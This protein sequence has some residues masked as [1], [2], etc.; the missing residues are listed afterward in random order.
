MA[1]RTL[2]ILIAMVSLL[3]VLP[4][5]H[6]GGEV[7]VYSYRQPFL[8]KP[9]LD[10]FSENTGIK[11]N[12]L[13]APKGLIERVKTE[14]KNSPADVVLTVD[15]GRL[16]KAVT[17]GVSQPVKSAAIEANVP[18]AY[19][20]NDGSWFGRGLWRPWGR[21]S[22]GGAYRAA[23]AHPRVMARSQSAWRFGRPTT[24]RRGRKPSNAST[25]LIPTSGWSWRALAVI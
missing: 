13:F 1:L 14:G 2:P 17:Q 11:V 9:M 8:I 18:A 10:A 5:A 4:A 21:A 16:T 25:R 19:R 24:Q 7:N 20:A 6:A 23:G 22:R 15:I 3:S 12:V